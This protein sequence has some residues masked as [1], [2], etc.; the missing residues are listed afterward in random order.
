MAITFTP[1][2]YA[3]PKE[4]KT[5]VY[6]N[7]TTTSGTTSGTFP[8]PSQ[9]DAL[10]RVIGPCLWSITGRTVSI[11]NIPGN[12]TCSLELVGTGL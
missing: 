4:D 3:H 11:T 9:L 7:V 10:E 1:E 6:V 2:E 12:G 5:G 8:L